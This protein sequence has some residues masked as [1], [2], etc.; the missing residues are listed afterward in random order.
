M[1]TGWRTALV[2]VL[3]VAAAPSARPVNVHAQAAPVVSSQEVNQ[4]VDVAEAPVPPRVRGFNTAQLVEWVNED[5][6][7]QL[8]EQTATAADRQNRRHRGAPG[9]ARLHGP[10][11]PPPED[12][13]H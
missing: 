10:Q 5:G 9:C 13:D 6:T 3:G 11:A 2:V 8:H 12:L 4:T 1:R 7:P